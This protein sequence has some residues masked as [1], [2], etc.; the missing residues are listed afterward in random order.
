MVLESGKS[1]DQL[2][3]MVATPGGTTEAGL[4]EMRSGRVMETLVR[5][6]ASATKRAADITNR[7]MSS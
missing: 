3:E 7:I 1:P 6:I 5:A 4:L 2:T